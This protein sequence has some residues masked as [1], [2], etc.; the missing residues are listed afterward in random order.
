MDRLLSVQTH[1]DRSCGWRVSRGPHR[2]S[3]WCTAGYSSRPLLF[4]VY[5]NDIV[6]SV[7]PGTTIR[8]FA[9]D[10]LLYLPIRSQEYQ[11]AVQ[12][13]LDFLEAWTVK[14]GMRFNP[15][16]CQVM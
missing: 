15:A 11:L 3:V 13:D 2:S 6:D 16:K 5:L 14:W 7:S 8:L 4:L 9:D 10:C 1:H 12:R